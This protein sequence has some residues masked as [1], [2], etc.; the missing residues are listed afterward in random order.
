MTSGECNAILSALAI[1]RE[2][3][4]KSHEDLRE[5]IHES[6]RGVH[7][8]IDANA[9]VTNSELQQQNKHFATL[10]GNVAR[11]QAVSNER[12][13]VIDDFRRLERELGAI[14]KKW[15][16]ILAGLVGLILVVLMIY[17]VVGLSGI[18]EMIK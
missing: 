4:E 9:K 3:N 6:I 8:D 14:K 16:Y 17:D 2:S 13:V 15:L 11:L 10:N 1:M 5:L 18:I 12:A 7:L